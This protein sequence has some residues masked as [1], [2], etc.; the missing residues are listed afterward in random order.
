MTFKD[1]K[2]EQRGPWLLT[3]LDGKAWD[4]VEHI[5]LETLAVS[6]RSQGMAGFTLRRLVIRAEG[7]REG[8]DPRSIE[9]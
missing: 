7:N 1:M 2:K 8:E 3:L 4:A 5:S 6:N 9:V